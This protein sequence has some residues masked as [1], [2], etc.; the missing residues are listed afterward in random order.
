MSK[1]AMVDE[2]PSPFEPFETAR[3]KLRCVSLRDALPVS[4]L[5]TE[6]ISRWVA[7]WPCPFSEKMAVERIRTMRRLGGEGDALPLAITRKTHDEL[8]G[9]IALVRDKDKRA[10]ASLGYWLGEAW[11]GRGYMKEALAA[12]IREGFRRLDSATIEAAA[13]PENAASIALMRA[14]GMW[15]IGVRSVFAPARNRDEPCVVFE[16]ERRAPA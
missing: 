5:M 11:Q 14:C 2:E 6:P 10:R 3:L 4:Q 16:I 8:I 15:E 9:W 13:Q 1:P 7:N 12:V